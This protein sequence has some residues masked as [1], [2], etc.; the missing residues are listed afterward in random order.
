MKRVFGILALAALLVLG[1]APAAPAGEMIFNL[2]WVVFGRHAP[3]YVALEKGYYKDAGLDIKIVR[4]YGSADAIN[5]ITT[6]QATFAFGDVGSL[7]IARSKGAQMKLVAM[8]YGKSPF[9]IFSLADAKIAKPKDLEGKSIAAPTFDSPRNMFPVFARAAGID[10]SKVKWVTV[11]GAQKDPML[12]AKRV[13]AITNFAVDAPV[14]LR[15]A[16]EQNVGLNIMKWADYGF[17]L[18]SNGILVSDE[19]IRSKPEAVKGFVQATIKGLRYAFDRP[20][21]AVALILKHHPTLDR[22]VARAELD[23]VKDM[24][25]TEDATKMGIGWINE[26]TMQTSVD[27]VAEVFKVEKSPLASLYTNEFLK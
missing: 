21:E 11:D 8:I 19:L 13:D 22:E 26:K 27:A 25:M 3:Y 4:G 23:I 18:Y 17:E 16:K 6:G 2:D 1:L 10:A 15:R 14:H 12:F 20:D 9:V 7:I 24:V 5:K